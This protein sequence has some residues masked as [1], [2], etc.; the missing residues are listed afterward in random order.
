MNNQQYHNSNLRKHL[1]YLN[2][3]ESSYKTKELSLS[4]L[5]KQ[6]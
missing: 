4:A 2:R 5:N 3:L 1:S 6:A